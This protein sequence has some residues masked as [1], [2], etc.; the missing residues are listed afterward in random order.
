VRDFVPCV[1]EGLDDLYLLRHPGE[2]LKQFGESRRACNYI[3]G[4]FLEEHKEILL[5]RHE[6]PKKAGHE[7]ELPPEQ[8]GSY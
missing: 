3:C 2:M 6:L 1:F 7:N 4:L 8:Q 5:S